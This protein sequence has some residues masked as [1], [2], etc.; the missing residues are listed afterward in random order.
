MPW[1]KEIQRMGY[2]SYW[3]QYGW[4]K[5]TI[6]H[7]WK[8]CKTTCFQRIKN[9]PVQYELN[10]K[11]W[12]TRNIFAEWLQ[13]LD[14]KMHQQ[15]WKIALIIVLLTRIWNLET[16]SCTFCLQIPLP[17]RIHVMLVLSKMWK[18]TTKPGLLAEWFRHFIRMK[19][20]SSTACLMHCIFF[21]ILGMQ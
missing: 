12:M 8:K 3:C 18:F 9:V 4:W 13:K 17:K 15:H 10:K 16:F 19:N 2:D 20:F 5:V 11:A 6:A 14:K 21:E 7:H 1:W